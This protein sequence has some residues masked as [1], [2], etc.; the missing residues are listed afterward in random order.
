VTRSSITDRDGRFRIPTPEGA[1]SYQLE[2]AEDRDYG[3]AAPVS[4]PLIAAS[5]DSDEPA[6]ESRAE[7]SAKPERPATIY[8]VP[9]LTTLLLVGAWALTRSRPLERVLARAD[10]RRRRKADSGAVREPPRK[11]LGT[12]R[13]MASRKISGRVIDAATGDPVVGA[14]V[15]IHQAGA[16]V[17]VVCDAAGAFS[18][19]ELASGTITV[20][21]GSGG[22]MSE[23]FSRTLP[24]RGEL[25]GLE[26]SLMPVRARLLRELEQA[27]Q[28]Y[29]AEPGRVRTPREMVNDAARMPTP[30]AVV[31]ALTQ[32]G[33]TVEKACWGHEV[34][35]E[36]LLAR[37]APILLKLRGD[38]G[39]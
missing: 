35:S 27:A 30:A 24:H 13:L 10:E 2:V 1:R 17:A 21:I 33:G 36:S 12:L 15:A 26:I 37:L 8:L 20:Q 31:E 18:S 32:L 28:P 4:G 9:P 25:E 11:L 39:P 22:Y 38:R 7:P 34:P 5:A 16:P 19:G 6:R 14:R 23:R 29:L 3:A